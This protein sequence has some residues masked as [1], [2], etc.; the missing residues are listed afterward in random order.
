MPQDIKV[1]SIGGLTCEPTGGFD[2]R[3]IKYAD[4]DWFESISAPKPICDA[5]PANEGTTFEELAEISADH[6]FKTGYGFMTLEAVQEST[7]L[8]ST[9]IGEKKRRLF[10]NKIT[11]VIAGSNSTLNGFV[12]WA[13]NRSCIV[14]ITEA[15][16][17]RTRQLGSERFA[18]EI[19][20]M[21]GKVEATAEG[22]NSKAITFSD[23][24]VYEAPIYTGVITD[25]PAQ[26]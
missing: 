14:L 24:Q 17:G 9:M 2:V 20:E 18:A 7:G 1:E 15:E 10:E 12:R 4:I 21:V 11:T 25:M 22:D 26:V 13:K 23:K 19:L 6:T 5:T 3:N 8:E 16:S